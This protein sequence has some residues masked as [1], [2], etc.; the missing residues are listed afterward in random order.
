MKYNHQPYEDWVLDP[1]GLD[2][3]QTR[4][5]QEHL[6][7]CPDCQRLSA[8]LGEVEASL[9]AQP[10]LS[11]ASGFTSRWQARLIA[12]RRRS[13]RRQTFLAMGFSIGG[14]MMLFAVL[15]IA[16]LPLFS[17][18]YPALWA[19]YSQATHGFALLTGIGDALAKLARIIFDIIPPTLWVAVMVAMGSLSAVWIIALQRTHLSR[20]IVE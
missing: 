15:L 4:Q 9:R 17:N 3:Q 2:L 14:A 5:L 12:D 19:A 10:V 16:L 11:P 7:T 6:H 1:A 18:P 8:A 13:Q 20:R